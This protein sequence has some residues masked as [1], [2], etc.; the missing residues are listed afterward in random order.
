MEHVEVSESGINFP[1][2][3]DGRRLDVYIG[4]RFIGH[5][6]MRDENT[7]LLLPQRRE[8]RA[9]LHGASGGEENPQ[10]NRRFWPI[11]SISITG[12]TFISPEKLEELRQA[13]AKVNE[14]VEEIKSRMIVP[15]LP[16]MP[17]ISSVSKAEEEKPQAGYRG[18]IPCPKSRK[19]FNHK[20]IK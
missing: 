9:V 15:L 18:F 4:D 6:V 3:A 2:E 10:G 5:G 13:F 16:A 12:T 8:D 14:S 19:R 7:L 17:K 20:P 1:F 11:N